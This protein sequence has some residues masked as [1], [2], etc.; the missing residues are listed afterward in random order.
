L[1]SNHRIQGRDL[2]APGLNDGPELRDEVDADPDGEQDLQ[3]QAHIVPAGLIQLHT[4]CVDAVGHLHATNILTLPQSVWYNVAGKASRQISIF[5]MLPSCGAQ[6]SMVKWLA[7]VLTWT[8]V[9]VQRQ[10][11][12]PKPP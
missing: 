10:K 8:V 6:R 1:C 11:A 4:H 7:T 9:C 5:Q 3:H 12:Q 2:T